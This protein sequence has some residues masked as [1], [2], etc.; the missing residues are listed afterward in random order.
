M[1][2]SVSARGVSKTF[3]EFEY[4]G[5]YGTPYAVI[6]TKE[7][8]KKYRL[9]ELDTREKLYY[10][11]AEWNEGDRESW[12]RWS[13]VL[14]SLDREIASRKE[15]ARSDGTAWD[16]LDKLEHVVPNDRRLI[17]DLAQDDWSRP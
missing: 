2:Q 13:E 14:D 1:G 15:K 9:Y 16:D 5:L 4:V 17:R 6:V 7:W 3:A 8:L 12:K 10:P 11:V